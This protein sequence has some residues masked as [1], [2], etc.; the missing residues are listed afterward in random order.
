MKN[1]FTKTVKTESSGGSSVEYE[2]PVI[3]YSDIVWYLPVA[4]EY[5]KMTSSDFPLSGTYWT[6]EAVKDN[7]RAIKYTVGDGV[8][9]QDLR[10]SMFRI[11]CARK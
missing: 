2:V 7:V 6:S 5:K 9:A 1:K 11:R 4:E 8:G 3:N 10:T